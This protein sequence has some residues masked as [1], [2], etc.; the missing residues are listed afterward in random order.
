[1]SRASERPLL[2]GL[3]VGT[4]ATKCLICD[5]EGRVVAQSRQDY[6]LQYPREGWVEQNPEDLWDAA[7]ATL[8]EASAAVTSEGHVAAVSLSAQGGTTI[9]VDQDGRPLRAA[10][11]WLDGR[12]VDEGERLTAEIGQ[13]R[14]YATTG[15]ETHAALPLVHIPWL[16]RNEPETYRRV[17]RYLFVNDFIIYRLT[18]KFMMDPSDAALTLLYSVER[19][20]WDDLLCRAAG[21]R[22]EQLS[23]VWPSGRPVGKLLPDAARQVGLSD[24]VLVVNGGHDQYCGALGSGVTGDGD[25]MLAS[26]TAWVLLAA[27]DRLIRDPQHTLSPGPHTIPGMWGLLCS[28]PA[29]G[30]S[31]E[32]LMRNV[33][34]GLD[35]PRPRY[36]LLDQHLCDVQ[37]GARGLLFLPLLS[38]LEAAQRKSGLWGTIT[39]LTLSH[40]RWEVAQALMEGVA[41]ELRWVLERLH[42]LGYQ[43]KLVHMIGGATR[44]SVWPQIVAD[45]TGVP[46]ALPN[47]AEAAARGAALLAGVGSGAIAGW[48]RLPRGGEAERLVRPRPETGPVYDKLFERFR[49]VDG[50]LRQVL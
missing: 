22:M 46:L 13:E 25:V 48:E 38:G 44:S 18:G 30:A 31:M 23:P 33:I 7:L 35:E 50:A 11:S 34:G 20:G 42:A 2:A 37:P 9:P 10:I 16:A 43:P 17:W 45:A 49:A 24:E 1:M 36:D 26:G 39:G 3:D 32:W 21:V 8:R 14:I 12:A 29:A 47:V 5:A 4:N 40:S 28:L 6:G 19:G 27:A 41:L 15:W